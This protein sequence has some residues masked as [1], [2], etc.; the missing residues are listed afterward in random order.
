MNSVTS[1]L[2]IFA[3]GLLCS[4]ALGFA[5]IRM[6]GAEMTF[7]LIYLIPI[8]V[9]AWFA[10]RVYG[11][12]LALICSMMWFSAYA[13]SNPRFMGSPLPY[14]NFITKTM[15]LTGF[16]V[17]LDK[18]KSSLKL[19]TSLS[20]TDY[21]TGTANS[22]AFVLDLER[23]IQR[24]GRYGSPLTVLYMDVDNFKTVNDKF[25][26]S[27]GDKLLKAVAKT[28]MESV[29]STDTVARMGGDEFA[30]LLL[31][32]GPESAHSIAHKIFARLSAIPGELKQDC[33]FSIGAITFRRV[34]PTADDIIHAA[35]SLMYSVKN[36]GKN[37]VKL[38]VAE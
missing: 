17:L 22:R 23:E 19:A 32:T 24:A 31:E 37:A 5:D 33:T 25:G 34:P 14:V 1:R 30:V 6:L 28:L 18:L 9:T 2:G 3:L 15:I 35:D 8:S 7:T 26:H 16:A 11:V 20:L 36:R 29:R 38:R 27:S 21:N 4:I 13:I 12:S 10:G